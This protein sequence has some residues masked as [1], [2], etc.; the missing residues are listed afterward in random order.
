MDSAVQEEPED[1]GPEHFFLEEFEDRAD[2]GPQAHLLKA[3]LL[4]Q[5]RPAPAAQGQEGQRAGT[6]VPSHRSRWT[7]STMAMRPGGA[8][9]SMSWCWQP[10]ACPG[11]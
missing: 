10:A 11:M 2:E 3:E 9:R 1:D 4:A 8:P 6:C 7:A 5:V